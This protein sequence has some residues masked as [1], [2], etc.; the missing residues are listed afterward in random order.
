MRTIGRKLAA[1][2]GPLSPIMRRGPD[3]ECTHCHEPI[4]TGDTYFLK[5]DDVHGDRPI[6]Y[7]CG[8]LIEFACGRMTYARA[9]DISPIGGP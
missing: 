5:T 1:E 4:R 6:C 3:V 2:L 9:R 7:R 8:I